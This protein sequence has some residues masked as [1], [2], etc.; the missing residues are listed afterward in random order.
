MKIILTAVI[1]SAAPVLAMAQCAGE[2]SD[3]QA[4]SC[5][6]GTHWDQESQSCLSTVAS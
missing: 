1:L 5:V 2:H 4:M 3:Q 6:T